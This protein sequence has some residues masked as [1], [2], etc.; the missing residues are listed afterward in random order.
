M[1]RDDGGLGGRQTPA[2][3]LAAILSGSWRAEPPAPEFSAGDL[4][5]VSSLLTGSGAGALAWWKIR[6]SGLSESEPARALREAYHRQTLQHALQEREIEYVFRLLRSRRVEPVLLKGWAAAALYPER[7]LR[8]PG[9]IDLC[10]RPEWHAAAVAVPW[11]PGRRG[12]G[13]I[14]LTHD[15]AYLLGG[16]S[17]WDDLY[18]RSRLVPLNDSQIRVLGL[19]DQLRFL[20]LHFLKHSAYRPLW[21]CDVAA[22]LE[23]AGDD[24]DWRVALGGGARER[25][26]VACVLDLACRLLGARCE[27][28]PEEVRA[29][30]APAW[31]A[32][33]VLRQWKRP[34]TSQRRPLELMSLSL[35]RPSRV[36]PALLARWPDPVCASVGLGL[37][38]D[39]SP[40]WPRQ[41]KFYLSR[42]AAFLK[43][44]LRRGE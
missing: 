25:N 16:G 40:R 39:E 2:Q 15:P 20:C 29:F 5:G 44:P 4:G 34:C 19:E 8:Q 33:E 18:A 13:I 26:W 24:F 7:G 12:R 32:A 27:H 1:A 17:S 10:V 42:A 36:L 43:R 21:L 28:I 3:L 23:A 6:R 14:D 30:R 11:E 41:V 35:R 31:L 38:L 37:I 22:A 9:D